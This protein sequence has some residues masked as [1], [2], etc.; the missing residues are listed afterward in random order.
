MTVTIH[1]ALLNTFNICVDARNT[2]QN[3]S[4]N[5]CG[6]NTLQKSNSNSTSTPST[7]FSSN[8]RGV[9]SQRIHELQEVPAFYW[10]SLVVGYTATD[11]EYSELD[12][13]LLIRTLAKF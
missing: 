10:R 8:N 12:I 13:T 1:S 9:T 5:M 6:N 7:F 4:E 2:G 3:N 11:E